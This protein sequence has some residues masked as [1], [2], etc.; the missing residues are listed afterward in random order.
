MT[1]WLLV[2]AILG[3]GFLMVQ[4]I[5]WVR[6]VDFGLTMTSSLYGSTFYVLIG[7]HGLHVAGGLVGLLVVL[8]QVLRE[9]HATG[10]RSLRLCR[11]YWWFVVGIWP[12]LYLL[13]YF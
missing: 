4:G 11:M 1:G 3:T 9:V 6:L 7:V 13:V 10:D 2:S 8:A 12:V 5:E